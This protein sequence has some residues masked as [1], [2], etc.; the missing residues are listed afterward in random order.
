MDNE[1]KISKG[2]V[3]GCLMMVVALTIWVIN[4]NDTYSTTSSTTPKCK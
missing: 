4:I 1:R 3:A 2:L